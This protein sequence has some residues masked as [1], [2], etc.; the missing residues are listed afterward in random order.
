MTAAT[1]AAGIAGTT[2]TSDGKP[3]NT[4]KTI[5]S[6]SRML[7]FGDS[8]LPVGAFA[9]SS[10]VESAV[11]Q[12]VIRDPDTLRDYA[13]TA[14]EQAAKGDGVVI[15]WATRAALGG[16]VKE[17]IRIDH[18]VI[19]RK[20]N[21]ETRLMTTRMGKKLAEMGA[22]ITE[23]PLVA[24]WRDA[25][26]DGRTPGTYPVALAL[27]FVVMGLSTQAQLD[28]GL[29]HEVLTV[30]L[31]G[32]A[33]TILNAS[34]RLMRI[35]HIDIQRVLYGLTRRFDPLCRMSM[36]LSLD[37]MSAFAPMTDILAANH[38]RARVRLFMN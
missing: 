2:A 36:R 10:G 31:Y 25:I 29:L 14:L 4:V 7:Q 33:M 35:T 24:L 26:R 16:N 5:L 8:M 17:L 20:L 6:L 38:V 1:N 9:F 28:A 23:N 3:E 34:M 21:E 12:G 22:E 30:H 13:L 18:E 37:Q 27:M 11:Q 32:V 19:A 15:V